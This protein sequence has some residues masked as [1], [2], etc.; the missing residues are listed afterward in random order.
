MSTL[1]KLF[2]P[3]LDKFVSAYLDGII[4]YSKT[5]EEHMEHLRT[6]RE[7]LR[8]HKLYG[9]MSK[10]DY[11]VQEIDNLGDVIN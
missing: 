8:K 7:I 4:M 11:A 6:A 3:Y 10:C 1:N 2:E 5:K 9:K